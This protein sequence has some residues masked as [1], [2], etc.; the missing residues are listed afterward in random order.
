VRGS[1]TVDDTILE[2]VHTARRRLEKKKRLKM[3]EVT[4]TK[5]RHRR[6]QGPTAACY[7]RQ[8]IWLDITS[9]E[10][11]G[12]DHIFLGLLEEGDVADVWPLR[13][14]PHPPAQLRRK[15]PSIGL[16]LRQQMLLLLIMM[17]MM[18]YCVDCGMYTSNL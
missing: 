11:A 12:A 1:G 3:K 17:M 9:L 5:T 15:M 8:K 4:V 7:S 2:I 6:R 14:H 18:S 13:L 10:A 16:I